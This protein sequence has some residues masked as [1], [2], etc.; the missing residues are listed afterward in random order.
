VAAG[1]HHIALVCKNMKETIKFYEGAM[2][3]KLR[4]IYPMHGI[5][6][7]KHCFLEVRPLSLFTPRPQD[8]VTL[9]AR[10]LAQAGNGNEISF[11]QFDDP[12]DTVNPKS[13][14]QVHFF[15]AVC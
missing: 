4:A 6:G 11:V 15:P 2:G 9:T 1:F 13:F 12:V 5:K 3:M 10:H 8:R 14:F 7:A